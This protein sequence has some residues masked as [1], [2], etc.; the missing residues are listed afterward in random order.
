MERDIVERLREIAGPIVPNVCT[1]AAEAI[2]RLRSRVGQLESDAFEMSKNMNANSP[3]AGGSSSIADRLR[4]IAD[5]IEHAGTRPIP[6]G[7]GGEPCCRSTSTRK[8]GGNP[9]RPSSTRS[10]AA[11]GWQRGDP[12][13]VL[14][15]LLRSGA[16]RIETEAPAMRAHAGTM[17]VAADE[18]EHLAAAVTGAFKAVEISQRHIETLAEPEE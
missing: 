7:T 3:A 4:A 12:I 8:T 11:G 14:A 18:L 16:E 6:S 17:L 15:I 1:D 13:G 10:L 5:E 2:E 9:S